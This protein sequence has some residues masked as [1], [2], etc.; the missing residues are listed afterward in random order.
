[1]TDRAAGKIFLRKVRNGR[2]PWEK[3]KVLR[4]QN[5]PPTNCARS[6]RLRSSLAPFI[7]SVI[8]V[9]E[10][11]WS[12]PVK[13]TIRNMKMD[14][15]KLVTNHIMSAMHKNAL[16]T[17]SILWNTVPSIWR[18]DLLLSGFRSYKR[19]EQSIRVLT[20]VSSQMCRNS[21][22]VSIF[23]VYIVH[24]YPVW[25]FIECKINPAVIATSNLENLKNQEWQP[26]KNLRMV[27][28]V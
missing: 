28:S 7:R 2:S 3:T 21:Q 1:M 15:R 20:R 27:V 12:L 17:G 5:M 6:I 26:I 14:T 8:F 25:S 16:R 23:N 18:Y 24:W 11:L 10:V 19:G 13:I 22:T 4:H 9:C